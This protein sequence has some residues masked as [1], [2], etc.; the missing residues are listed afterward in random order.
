MN[1]PNNVNEHDTAYHWQRAW[2]ATRGSAAEAFS[3]QRR[4]ARM[5]LLALILAGAVLGV[6]IVFFAFDSPTLRSFLLMGLVGSLVLPGV[7]VVM[8]QEMQRSS[9]EPSSVRG[10]IP[11]A[12]LSGRAARRLTP[13]MRDRLIT[14]ADEGLLDRAL[15]IVE[16]DAEEKQSDEETSAQHR[17]E[18]IMHP[19]ARTRSHD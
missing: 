1:H 19:E 10:A 17:A 4:N 9:D 18:G 7:S 6:G 13:E 8:V 15:N 5:R 11:G 2:Y 3:A 12:H 16:R 14:A